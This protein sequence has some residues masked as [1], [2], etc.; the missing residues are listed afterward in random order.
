MTSLDFQ[1]VLKEERARRRSIREA[2]TRADLPSNLHEP[3]D[4]SY[5]RDRRM[6]GAAVVANNRRSPAARQD[7]DE[8]P[9]GWKEMPIQFAPRSSVDLGKVRPWNDGN[10]L[11]NEED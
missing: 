6:D 3:V 10:A 1:A 2:G 5:P 4:D 9:T 8:L 11:G 7:R